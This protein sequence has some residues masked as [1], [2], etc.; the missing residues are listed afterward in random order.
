[1]SRFPPLSELEVVGIQDR[2]IPYQERVSLRVHAQMD[3][4]QFAIVPGRW[5]DG[6]LRPTTGAFYQFPGRPIQPG[7]WIF[8]YT[9]PGN[10]TETFETGTRMPALVLHWGKARTLFD[11]PSTSVALLRIAQV[12]FGPP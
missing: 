11:D 10:T 6:S 4:G 1:M 5:V 8:L 2:G 9:G 3:L 12:G 7:Q